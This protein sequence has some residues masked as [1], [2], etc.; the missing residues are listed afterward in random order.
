M[1]DFHELLERY[2]HLKDELLSE[3]LT[4]RREKEVCREL[5]V[6]GNAIETLAGLKT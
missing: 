2:N 5:S 1:Q 4:R 3:K 6:I